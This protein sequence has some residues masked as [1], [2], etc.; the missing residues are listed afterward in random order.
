MD[1]VESSCGLER[2]WDYWRGGGE[3]THFVCCDKQTMATQL[4]TSMSPG[5]GIQE[6]NQVKL[7]SNTAVNLYRLIGLYS[8]NWIHST[9]WT[10]L[11]NWVYFRSLIG[12][13]FTV[14]S[15]FLLFAT[16]LIQIVIGCN[17]QTDVY[18]GIHLGPSFTFERLSFFR[19]TY[20]NHFADN[21]KL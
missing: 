15:N 14:F 13:F 5:Q 7:T 21:S 1:S 9:N 18:N 4:S 8:A 17:L 11:A 10:I 16:I 6:S 19:I 3:K 20:H 12:L 2:V